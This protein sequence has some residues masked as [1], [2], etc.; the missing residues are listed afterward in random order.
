M[1]ITSKEMAALEAELNRMCPNWRLVYDNDIGE[2]ARDCGLLTAEDVEV[3]AE[4]DE[5]DFSERQL[6]RRLAQ[7]D[8]DNEDY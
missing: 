5:L 2:A 6:W 8:T 1:T 7:D 4:Y 3:E